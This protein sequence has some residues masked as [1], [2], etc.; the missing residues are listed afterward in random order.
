MRGFFAA[1]ALLT[2]IPVPRRL[3]G[4][5]PAAPS[6][7]LWWF[8]PVGLLIGALAAGAT[9]LA[10]L[11]LPWASCAAIGVVAVVVLSGGL[12]LDGFMDTCDGLGSR[13]PRERAL[14]IMR[15]PSAGAFGVIAAVCLLLLKFGL[16][17]GMEPVW[18]L[19]AIGL[20]PMAGRLMQVAILEGY[21][22]AR[23]EGGM[24]AGFF[25]AATKWHCMAG[26]LIA[27]CVLVPLAWYGVGAR[28]IG[29][30]LFAVL[31][32]GIWGEWIARRLGGHT[33]DTV[34]AVSELLEL[35]FVLSLAVF[36][37]F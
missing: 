29:S 16:V 21:G 8:V 28:G 17:A 32:G 19:L 5:A 7:M 25:A 2:T 33:G 37:Q 18:G 30:L 10:S 35:V 24:A 6:S 9:Y 26:I 23:S 20:A 1:L 12:H 11:A 27:V 15:D 14:E 36:S 4:D 34:G 3:L 13:A 31:A 22:Y